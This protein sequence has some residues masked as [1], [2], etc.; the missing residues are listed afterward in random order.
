MSADRWRMVK[1]LFSR[2]LKLA[3][4]EWPAYLDRVSAG[5]AELRREVA[6]LLAEHEPDATSLLGAFSS[7]D[8]TLR[9]ERLS[10][11]ATAAEPEEPTD[12]E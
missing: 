11:T 2:A 12:A 10:G 9:F 4:D 8:V 7:E 3:P 5:D 6:S 1:G